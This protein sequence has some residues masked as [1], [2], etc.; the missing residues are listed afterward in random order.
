MP[1]NIVTI[2]YRQC[3]PEQCN[4]GSCLAAAACPLKIIGQE[5]PFDYPMA[6]PSPCRGCASCAA[7]CP[8]KAITI[9]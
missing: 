1:D 6:K 8:F 2:N 7:A 3:Q 9:K 4:K 5:E